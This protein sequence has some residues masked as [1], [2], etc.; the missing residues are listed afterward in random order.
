L[1]KQ[2]IFFIW[3]LVDQKLS[4]GPDFLW[5]WSASAFVNIEISTLLILIIDLQSEAVSWEELTE[6]VRAVPST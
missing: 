3:W 1:Q 2:K 6:R 4:L 5:F